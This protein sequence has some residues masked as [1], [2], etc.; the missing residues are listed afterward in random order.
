MVKMGWKWGAG[1]VWVE[2]NVWDVV[3][4]PANIEKNFP[5]P[6]IMKK[7]FRK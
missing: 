3:V 4:F 5:V 1:G 6:L 2:E 7:V